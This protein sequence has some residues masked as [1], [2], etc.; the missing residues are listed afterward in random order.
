LEDYIE[1]KI[2][3]ELIIY[4]ENIFEEDYKTIFKEIGG[5][6]KIIS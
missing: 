1:D 3:K 6:L 5:N 4:R 2:F